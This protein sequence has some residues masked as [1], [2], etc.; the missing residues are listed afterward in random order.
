MD[1]EIRVLGPLEASVAG[2]P[3]VPT[4][5]KQRQMLAMFALN[6]GQVLT[7][8]ALIEE[9]WDRI[10]P[11]SAM[12]TI[13]T[14]ILKLRRM[15]RDGFLSAGVTSPDE[16]LITRPTGYLLD[17]P[18]EHVDA[19]L[20]GRLSAAGRRAADDGDY[21]TASVTLAAALALWRAPALIDVATGPQL[22]IEAIGLEESRL[23]DLGL[24]IDADLRFGRHD[25]LLSEL[26]TLCAR[27]PLLEK[28]CGQFM[29]ALYRSGR[30][31]QALE[32]YQRT[33]DTLVNELGLDPSPRLRQLHQAMLAG[34]PSMYDMGF[35]FSGQ[36]AGELTAVQA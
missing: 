2:V 21:A 3:V 1:V 6:A 35:V 30:L 26:A 16:I 14:Y 36:S 11:R 5:N 15:I 23:S 31:P 19:L 28:F 10:P 25:Q 4:A 7:V 9:L 13:Q 20:Y 27:Y 29:L 34:H 8:D 33:R 22:R 17:V 18:A 12:T 32:V 24:R